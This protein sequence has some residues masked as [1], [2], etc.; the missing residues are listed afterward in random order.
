RAR[1]LDTPANFGPAPATDARSARELRRPSRPPSRS[2]GAL[3]PVA[4]L[5]A[6]ARSHHLGPQL[7][8]TAARLWAVARR[9]VRSM[10]TDAIPGL[11][12]LEPP[13][14]TRRGPTR[15]Q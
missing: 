8:P 13:S 15:E 11:E 5:A 6:L 12:G 1:R 14:T 9:V 3:P 10:T 7:G 2:R 4:T